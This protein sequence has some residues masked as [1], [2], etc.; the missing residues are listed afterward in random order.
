MSIY[1][2]DLESIKIYVLENQI[3]DLIKLGLE[4]LPKAIKIYKKAIK[5]DIIYRGKKTLSRDIARNETMKKLFRQKQVDDV[6]TSKL[7]NK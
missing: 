3:L 1:V 5:K 4:H 2:K 7:Y 6:I